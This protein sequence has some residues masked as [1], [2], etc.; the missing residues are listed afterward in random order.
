MYGPH[1]CMI[2]W[3]LLMAQI[4]YKV[5]SY[6]EDR[7][8]LNEFLMVVLLKVSYYCILFFFMISLKFSPYITI[9]SIL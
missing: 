5:T 6:S 8:F 4:L 1:E 3:S 9:P 7:R 2:V